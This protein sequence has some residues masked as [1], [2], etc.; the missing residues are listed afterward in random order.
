M[1]IGLITGLVIIFALNF[2]GNSLNT[3]KT[4]FLAKNINKPT[5]IIVF[6]EAAIFFSSI[7][8]VAQGDGFLYLLT[9]ALGKTAGTWAGNFIENR[10][11]L[12]FVEISI[13]A[14]AEKA[15]SAADAIRKKG[16]SVTTYKGYG[17]NGRPSFEVNITINRKEL[18]A[19]QELFAEFELDNASMVI[20]EVSAVSGNI[21][22]SGA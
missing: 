14:A 6:I 16:Y 2:I 10:I 19:L 9:F 20:R 13:F 18:P 17:Y 1:T 22:V 4:I 12:G 8:Q 5:Y 15:K 11:A 21:K 3:L 7:N